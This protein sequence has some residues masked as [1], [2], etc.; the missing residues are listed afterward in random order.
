V[1]HPEVLEYAGLPPEEILKQIESGAIPDVAAGAL[2]LAWAKVRQRVRIS[3]V[4]GGIAPEAA[5][6]LGFQPFDNVQSAL[7][8]SFRRHGAEASLAVLPFA[9]DTLPVV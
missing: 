6:A 8:E 9:P 2:A 4:S 1:M 5:R 7:D 3:L